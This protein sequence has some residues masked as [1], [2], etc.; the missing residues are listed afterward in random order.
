MERFTS[1]KF[2]GML[3]GV[4]AVFIAAIL[5]HYW[6]ISVDLMYVF[7]FIGTYTGIEGIRDLGDILKRAAEV[8]V[9]LENPMIPEVGESG[10]K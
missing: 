2:L 7:A 9:A 4:V 8:K 5:D 3:L 6:G 10:E 1:R